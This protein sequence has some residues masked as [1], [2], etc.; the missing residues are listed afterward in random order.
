MPHI[1]TSDKWYKQII[2]LCKQ[3][4]SLGWIIQNDIQLSVFWHTSRSCFAND[5]TKK[6]KVSNIFNMYSKLW[7]WKDSWCTIKG[8]EF[9]DI[10][11]L[12]Y[13]WD[14]HSNN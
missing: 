13:L 12:I 1:K 14:S 8:L 11:Y 6:H 4:S 7:I 10:D 2:Q 5:A 3:V 9:S